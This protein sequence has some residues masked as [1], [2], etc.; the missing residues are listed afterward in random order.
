TLAI[1]GI[2]LAVLQYGLEKE[3]G[4]IWATYR[5]WLVMAALG[6]LFVFLGRAAVI[7]GVCLISIAG[8]RELARASGLNA[9]RMLAGAVYLGIAAIGVA[10]LVSGRSAQF[11][12][13]NTVAL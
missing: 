9:D 3:L 6:L 2:V 5:S 12:T 4:S 10:S 8:F 13:F 1:A 7:A 11:T